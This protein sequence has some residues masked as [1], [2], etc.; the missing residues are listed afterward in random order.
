MVSLS[1]IHKKSLVITGS[2]DAFVFTQLEGREHPGSAGP[3]DADAPG[4]LATASD[5]AQIATGIDQR[6]CDTHTAQVCDGPVHR[7]ALG[8]RPEVD[9]RR[10]ISALDLPAAIRAGRL[11]QA[12]FD[13]IHE[14]ARD[15]EPVEG[16][17]L[18]EAGGASDVDF[19]EIV[20]DHVEPHEHEPLAA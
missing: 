5:G 20:A 14:L 4:S 15:V 13:G 18:A 9:L 2:Q 3:T 12:L 8:V 6:V 17:Q 7:I 1:I 11:A 19:G 10:R 16:V